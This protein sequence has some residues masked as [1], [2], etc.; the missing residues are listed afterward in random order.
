V[1]VQIAH[2]GGEVVHIIPGLVQAG[3]EAVSAADA[4][5]RVDLHIVAASVVAV[6]HRTSRNAGVAIDAFVLINVDDLRLRSLG[7]VGGT[8]GILSRR[9]MRLG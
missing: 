9:R 4:G 1:V 7:D 3:L 2:E 6:L 8:H 5:V